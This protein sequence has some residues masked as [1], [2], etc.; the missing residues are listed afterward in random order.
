MLVV[1]DRDGSLIFAI[2]STT[3][4]AGPIHDP[5]ALRFA[6]A[7]VTISPNAMPAAFMDLS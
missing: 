4:V 1:W 7:G 5:N 3:L 6:V 2:T